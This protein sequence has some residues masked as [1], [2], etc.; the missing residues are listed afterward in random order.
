MT[1]DTVSKLRTHLLTCH[2]IENEPVL[3]EFA[4]EEGKCDENNLI[5]DIGYSAVHIGLNNLSSIILSLY[6]FHF[7]CRL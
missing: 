5:Y 6:F 2:E 7:T 3:H 1:F 4:S